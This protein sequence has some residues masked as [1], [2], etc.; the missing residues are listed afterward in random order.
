[1]AGGDHSW[2]LLTNADTCPMRNVSNRPTPAA[3]PGN[4][5]TFTPYIEHAG[6]IRDGAR[7]ITRHHRNRSLRS[8]TPRTRLLRPRIGHSSHEEYA[9]SAEVTD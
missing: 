8:A 6:H 3:P 7:L 4:T 2:P 1:M 9:A 5:G